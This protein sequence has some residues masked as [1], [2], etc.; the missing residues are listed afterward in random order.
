[1]PLSSRGSVE[2]DIGSTSLR[3]C[4]CIGKPSISL[5][6]EKGFNQ[7]NTEQDDRSVV[8]QMKT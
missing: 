8:E 2:L 1:M 5:I 4:N 7:F 3:L 6:I